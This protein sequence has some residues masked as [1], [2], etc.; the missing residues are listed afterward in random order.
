MISEQDYKKHRDMLADKKLEIQELKLAGVEVV[1]HDSGRGGLVV[2]LSTEA[3]MSSIWALGGRWEVNTRFRDRTV[4]NSERV[5]TS[6]DEAWAR[7][8]KWVLD[9]P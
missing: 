2:V 1:D 4:Y 8:K 6:L 9:D 5:V 3:R 7:A